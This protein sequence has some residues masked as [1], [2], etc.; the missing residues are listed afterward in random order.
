MQAPVP[1]RSTG[2][3]PPIPSRSSTRAN[4]FGKG[5]V[6]Q[7]GYT[8]PERHKHR[9]K[10]SRTEGRILV[11][12]EV[13]QTFESAPESP[14]RGGQSVP[15]Q[16]LSPGKQ[17]QFK[18]TS[19]SVDMSPPLT[20]I[21]V[22]NIDDTIRA[23]PT[24]PLTGAEKE[25]H[26]Q[27][28]H[29]PKS[30]HLPGNFLESRGF[31]RWAANDESLVDALTRRRSISDRCGLAEGSPVLSFSQQLIT[32]SVHQ[33]KPTDAESPAGAYPSC[34]SRPWIALRIP[35]AGRKIRDFV[36]LKPWAGKLP[37]KILTCTEEPKECD[38]RAQTFHRSI[39]RIISIRNRARKPDKPLMDGVQAET[40]AAPT[41]QTEGED[42]FVEDII[43]LN[44]VE[45]A[46]KSPTQEAIPVEKKNY[47]IKRLSA[48][49]SER[50]MEFEQWYPYGDR[51]GHVWFPPEHVD[52]VDGRA[53]VEKAKLG[54]DKGGGATTVNKQLPIP[55]S[56]L[57]PGLRTSS[58]THLQRLSTARYRDTTA[59]GKHSEAPNLR[60]LLG[61][62]RASPGALQD[63]S[64]ILNSR[65]FVEEQ[66]QVQEP[67]LS[68]A[69][70]NSPP[71]PTASTSTLSLSVIEQ[72][73][74]ETTEL[75]P[76]ISG[77]V[78]TPAFRMPVQSSGISH[79]ITQ[80]MRISAPTEPPM[81]PLPELPEGQGHEVLVD[82][83]NGSR[84]SLPSRRSHD[85]LH[86]Q[87]SHARNKLSMVSDASSIA[88]VKAVTS[89]QGSPRRQSGSPKKG[90]SIRSSS[91]AKTQ[92]SS[93]LQAAIA[94]NLDKD[95]DWSPPTPILTQDKSLSS[96]PASL[97]P[98]AGRHDRVR[99]I[100]LRD[101][102]SYR[103]KN[104]N[105]R[106]DAAKVDVRQAGG[107]TPGEGVD[108]SQFPAPPTSRPASR[109]DSI[110][111]TGS[112]KRSTSPRDH[113]VA[114][115]KIPGNDVL[116]RSKIMV[117]AESD[118]INN[119][120]Q[121]AVLSPA[122]SVSSYSRTRRAS[123]MLPVPETGVTVPAP[124][125]II[126]KES[127]HSICSHVSAAT[128]YG[129]HTP[130]RSESSTTSSDEEGGATG[131]KVSGGRGPT[132]TK[133]SAGPSQHPSSP[134]MAD[135][136]LLR[137]ID[138]VRSIKKQMQTQAHRLH[139]YENQNRSLVAA[140]VASRSMMEE[141][142]RVCA[143]RP[144]LGSQRRESVSPV[145]TRVRGI[146]ERT[147]ATDN[148]TNAWPISTASS[149]GSEMFES[150]SGSGSDAVTTRRA[151]A[152]TTLEGIDQSWEDLEKLREAKE[153]EVGL[154][155]SKFGRGPSDG[156]DVTTRRLQA[157]HA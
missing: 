114:D 99:E 57:Q 80:T 109:Q 48:G 82:V 65:S 129:T 148:R 125:K 1:V 101:T 38:N 37:A 10:A 9:I 87:A 5:K 58:K 122:P 62:P 140:L 95:R 49:S 64:N 28:R 52:N 32:P 149:S 46:D 156:L 93:I 40:Y 36:E 97:N 110:Q 147:S 133:G 61:Q 127:Q 153:S 70:S 107:R 119:R 146:R 39:P 51:Y 151:S 27:H 123:P 8:I 86:G 16:C 2:S 135:A 103:A 141:A 90:S 17:G 83:W 139:T 6:A 59:S 108:I 104:D 19:S 131:V 54:T 53:P 42:G 130:P 3:P 20:T 67:I 18:R 118:P 117:L 73:A 69:L 126:P 137:K 30:S 29:R 21:V 13:A 102:A 78:E 34:A 134:T 25:A 15:K 113:H 85:N 96:H 112:S 4:T 47:D 31:R 76:T 145:I 150:A 23:N 128:V 89:P 111:R 24:G 11:T 100:K 66:F 43:D 41:Y 68:N 116:S 115:S 74:N 81:G 91:S 72:S 136:D 98:V 56:C 7:R 79:G 94:H 60:Q 12:R 63:T 142:L 152:S 154:D 44:A 106:P 88:T 26:Q 138:Q 33:R 14:L 132:P 55:P 121:A 35:E 50:L 71:G 105:Y 45:K 75:P 77:D 124:L 84:A 144:P 92:A 157:Y 143:A 120:F 155:G 22:T